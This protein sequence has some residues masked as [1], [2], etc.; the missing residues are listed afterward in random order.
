M[1]ISNFILAAGLAL[2]ASPARGAESSA[3]QFLR[4]GF[5]ARALGMGEA[6]CAVADDASALYYNPAGLA[7]AGAEGEKSTLFSH[8][9]HVQEM[10]VSHAALLSRPW[11]FGLTYFSAGDLEG[12]DAS[13]NLTGDFTARDL[14]FSAGKGFALGAFRAGASLKYVDQ[15]IDD[16]SAHAAAADLGL[17]Y[18]PEGS[19]LRYGAAL[20]NLGTKVKFREE[21]Y[22]LPL[23]FMAGASVV[24]EDT[25]LMLAAQVELPNDSDAALRLGAEYSPSKNLRLRFG[26]K[27]SSSSDRDAILGRELGGSSGGVSSLFGFFA[28]AGVYVGGLSLDYALAPYGDL[29]SAHRVS[30]S[31]RL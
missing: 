8:G 22:P 23:T 2:A 30:V 31:M 3:A 26:Y 6:F 14:A 24:L 15:K 25:P 16:S 4:L 27:T 7:D 1:R 18:L 19:G 12:R 5:G 13:G 11:G 29:G 17:L 28:G 9:W 21:S 10:G 20:S